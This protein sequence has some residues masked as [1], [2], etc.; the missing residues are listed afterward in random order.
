MENKPHPTKKLSKDRIIAIFEAMGDI[1]KKHGSYFEI[2]IYGGSALMLEFDYREST[3]DI[4]YVALQGAQST[5]EAIANIACTS[6]G[7]ENFVLRDDVSMFVSDIASYNIYG[8]FPKGNGNL[9]VFTAKPQ[10]IFA[11]KIMAMRNSMETQ[12]LRDIWEIAD[13]CKIKTYQQAVDVLQQ[14]YPGKKLPVRNDLILQD[15]F[16]AKIQNKKYSP[17]I[18]W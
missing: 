6:M 12:D 7:L 11:M 3:V 15:I 17:E 8:E 18:G 10:Y 5:I 9:R 13:R 2:A 1:C 16:Y 4:D 14:Y